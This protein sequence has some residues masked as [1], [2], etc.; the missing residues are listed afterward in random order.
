M[1][2]CTLPCESRCSVAKLLRK[3][4]EDMHVKIEITLWTESVTGETIDRNATLGA[5]LSFNIKG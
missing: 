5:P 4:L 1:T 3:L 2:F